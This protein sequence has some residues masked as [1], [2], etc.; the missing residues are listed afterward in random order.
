MRA[1][2]AW[3]VRLAGLARLGRR[4]RD[5]RVEL[6]SLVEMHIED[7]LRAGLAPDEARR[8][9][10]ARVG[11]VDA[12]REAYR[13]RAGVPVLTVLAD[14]CRHGVRAFVRHRRFSLTV[15]AILAVGV[16][17]TAALIGAVHALLFSPPAHVDAPD[18]LVRV[19]SARNYPQFQELARRTRALG[20]TAYTRRTALTLGRG[21]SARPIEAQCVT[22][23][24]FTVLGTQPIAGRVF[25]ADDDTRGVPLAVLASS[26]WRQDFGGD[27]ALIGTTVDIAG[28]P[29]TVVG[30]AP[31]DFRGLEM[32]SLDAW[33][34]LPAAPEVCSLTGTND[35][36]LTSG[37]W[38]TVIGRLRTDVSPAIAETEVRTL[39]LHT[40]RGGFRDS[41]PR[42]LEPVAESRSDRA[43]DDG[44]LAVWV[45][46]G[47][48]LL[49]LI[50]CANVAGLLAVRAVDRRREIAV[51]LHLGAGR[52][53]L[54]LQ[55]LAE[56]VAL[57]AACAAVGWVVAV[58]VTSLLGSFL[59]AMVRESWLDAW[60]LLVVG[61]V[62][63]AAT[64]I[65]SLIPAA[66]MA[67]TSTAG[68]WRGGR[69]SATRS[70]FRSALLVAQIAIALT[71]TVGATLFARSVHA[72]K[73]GLGY[74]LDRVI[75]ASID[76]DRAGIRRQAEKWLVFE[77]ILERVR[78]LPSVEA[79]SLT[80][81]APLG[82]GRYSTVMPS[83]AGEEPG[84][85]RLFGHVSSDYFRTLGTR[86]TEGR[87]F[88]EADD[89]AGSR[90]AILSVA[91]AR[92]MWPGETVVGRCMP[93]VAGRD[94]VRIVGLSE[95]RR[96]G[97][98]T[99]I[100]G[101]IFYPLTRTGER[102]PQAVLVRP[103][104]RM[105]AAMPA[106]AGAI[107]SVAPNLPYINIQTLEDLANVQARSWRLGATLFG[108]FGVLAVV[109][110]ATGIYATL[111]F[112]VRQR[113]TEIG[114]RLAL[115]AAPREISGLVVRHGLRLIAIG[116][117]LGVAGSAALAHGIAAML[118][119]VTPLNLPALLIASTVVA[120]AAL[121]GCL[122][123]AMR[124]ARID[125]AIAL[126]A[127]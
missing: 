77:R 109:L 89:M 55:L 76:L 13:D 95:T 94:C 18:R 80:T 84:L 72:A 123:P 44:R 67:R 114:I 35:L 91:L 33:I 47:S 16:G 126:R 121:V 66:Q 79:A 98:L 50:A 127:E 46:A 40:I 30:V 75:V 11:S 52:G 90:V 2:R 39:A 105:A 85:M 27:P 103:R 65:A 97:S 22:G 41:P 43:R 70:R 7:G 38:L 25:A 6:R 9:A 113:T 116:W 57:A 87:A 107:R 117:L 71:L 56:N 3:I 88:D 102:L 20:V 118:F 61:G 24:Y 83:A 81:A 60:T 125:P 64:V 68:L 99:R 112:A 37:S 108:L 74:D 49:L 51:R 58:G 31:L 8:V 5:L 115:G 86:I 63:L 14:A 110:A 93:L 53:R 36:T 69:S 48:G 100:D 119:G 54:F 28:R 23:S 82:S 111:A 15:V 1:L 101:E 120:G 124:A 21:E 45:A 34:L 78:A 104:G 122:L 92:E 59:P 10:L 32:A 29:H 106:V 17:S 62:A 4:D 42:E 73:T 26:S 12:I 96:I 19:V